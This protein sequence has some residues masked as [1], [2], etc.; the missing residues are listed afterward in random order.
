MFNECKIRCL[1]YKKKP[2][3]AEKRKV[4]MLVEFR[5][6]L[7]LL[8]DVSNVKEE[9]NTISF[10]YKGLFFLFVTDESD[11]YYIRLLLPN[12]ATID[13][14]KTDVDVHTVINEYNNK[15]KVVKVSLWDKSVWLSIEQ[16]L[17]SKERANDLFTR[18][19]SIL[20]VVINDFRHEYIKQ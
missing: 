17:Y 5:N 20:E 2:I 19:I 4:D 9:N 12:I 18:A 7:S 14:L 11:Q 13:N 16:F 8:S 10:E 6:Y 3:F 1:M 15:F